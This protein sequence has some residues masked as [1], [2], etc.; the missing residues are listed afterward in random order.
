MTKERAKDIAALN[1]CATP[2]GNLGEVSERLV[3][4]LSAVDFVLAE[5]TRVSAKLLSAFSIKKELIR[6]DEHSGL[7]KIPSIIERLEAGESCAL[8]SDAGLPVVSDP[9]SNLVRAAQDAKLSVSG[10]AGPSAPSFAFALSGLLAKNFYF[11]AYLPRKEAEIRKLMQDL[12][13]L[14]AALIFFESPKRLSKSLNL[15]AQIFPKREGVIARELTKLHE[16][17]LRLPLPTLA[18]EFSSR[19]QIKGEIVVLIG[20]PSKDELK[21][22]ITDEELTSALSQE[23]KAGSSPSRAARSVA[24]RFLVP[25]NRVYLLAKD[26]EP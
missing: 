6:F 21:Q 19:E 3:A 9:G 16:E 11:G 1:I 25:K 12:A 2:I 10:V 15:L 24:E 8:V 5:D 23:I 26:I 14:D 18:E 7:Q 20:P 4:T 17:V 13:T 22:S